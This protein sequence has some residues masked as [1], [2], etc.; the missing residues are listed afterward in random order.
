MPQFPTANQAEN[1]DYRTNLFVPAGAEVNVETE[2]YETVNT[3]GKKTFCTFGKEKRDHTI[4]VANVKPYLKAKRALS[5]LLQELPS[6]SNSPNKT[7]IPA[8]T[9]TRGLIEGCE[10]KSGNFAES[11]GHCLSA[12]KQLKDSPYPP[13]DPMAKVL[14]DVHSRVSRESSEM[15]CVLEQLDQ[16]NPELGRE[17]LDAEQV[18]REIDKLLQDCRGSEATSV[19]K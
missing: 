10:V 19:R 7:C 8:C 16:A 18:V 4:L 6:A 5:P 14:G 12:N 2:S 3:N 9:S 15:D 13:S 17:A 11:S 1:A